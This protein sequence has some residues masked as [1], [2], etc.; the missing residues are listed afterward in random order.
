[1]N[2]TYDSKRLLEKIRNS[3]IKDKNVLQAMMSVP[4]DEF[5]AQNMKPIAYRDT[6]LPIGQGQTISQPSLVAHMTKELSLDK[7]KTVLELGTG[8]GY[9]TAILSELAQDVYTIET[10]PEL[11]EQA[12]ARLKELGYSHIHFKVGDGRMGWREAAP[13]DAII[14]TAAAD[15]VPKNLIAQLKVGG[16]M[17]IPLDMDDHQE[18]FLFIKTQ[19]GLTRKSLFPVRFVPVV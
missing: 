2:V 3:G 16:R 12:Q 9:Q 5:V 15:D 1:M 4:R 7:S 19:N 18:L 10:R 17:V 6:P 14:V 13:F 8:C 11:S